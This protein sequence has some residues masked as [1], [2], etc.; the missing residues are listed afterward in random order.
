[1]ISQLVSAYLLI[2][3]KRRILYIV[4]CVLTG[5]GMFT[6]ATTNY[7]IS[8]SKTFEQS[9]N[10]TII[11]SP[12]NIN[13]TVMVGQSIGWLPLAAIMLVAVG[14]HIGLSPITWSY[15]GKKKMEY[16]IDIVLL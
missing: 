13:E 12:S 5:T 1:M 3:L 10:L 15:T 4:S 8:S 2:K 7:M 16:K 9:T 14:Y 6:F 11:Q